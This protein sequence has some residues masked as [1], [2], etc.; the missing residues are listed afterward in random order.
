QT[1]GGT[2]QYNGTGIKIADLDTGL[3]YTHADFAGTGTTAAWNC[4]KAHGD[5]PAP[6]TATALANFQAS[7]PG[8]SDWV[9]G[10]K[11]K[12]GTDLVG[13]CYDAGGRASA[14]CPSGSAN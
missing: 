4:A 12:G 5:D 10:T 1:W 11:V 13:N 7:C 6:D 14:G 2:G 9:T 8:V 3:D